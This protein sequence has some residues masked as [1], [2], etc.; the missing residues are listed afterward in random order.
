ME[1]VTV[2]VLPGHVAG[3]RPTVTHCDCDRVR[4]SD[5]ESESDGSESRGPAAEARAYLDS[6][7]I[8]LRDDG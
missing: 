6:A 4:S 7:F 3:C 8:V 2:A 1:D 5:S